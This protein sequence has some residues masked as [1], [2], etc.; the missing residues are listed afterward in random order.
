MRPLLKGSKEG[1]DGPAELLYPYAA[2]PVQ[3]KAGK[4]GVPA[5]IPH[6]VRKSSAIMG[7]FRQPIIFSRHYP[8]KGPFPQG[9]GEKALLS[10][11]LFGWGE[12][13]AYAGKEPMRV[14]CCC[15]LKGNPH[16]G[17]HGRGDGSAQAGKASR[18]RA[19]ILDADRHV[20]AGGKSLTHAGG[21][22]LR[23]GRRTA[24]G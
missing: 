1:K 12:N 7:A 15:Y 5:G 21:E 14:P 22:G 3:G 4:P 18:M 24:P 17:R 8:Q 13:L 11:I 20:H 9:D 6:G 10:G 23:Y 16:Q 19:G 2:G